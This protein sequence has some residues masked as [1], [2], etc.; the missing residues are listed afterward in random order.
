MAYIY[1]WE[2]ERER[3]NEI[4]TGYIAKTP[5]LATAQ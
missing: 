4:K 3:E 5:L 2:L 1:Q